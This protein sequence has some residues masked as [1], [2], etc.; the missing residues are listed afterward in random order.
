MPEASGHRIREFI[1]IVWYIFH[2]Y[3]YSEGLYSSGGGQFHRYSTTRV[4]DPVILR[5]R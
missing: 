4:A 1:S 2:A 3:F 5:L